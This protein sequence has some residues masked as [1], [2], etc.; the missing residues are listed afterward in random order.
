[1][2]NLLNDIKLE[3]EE[4]LQIFVAFLKVQDNSLILLVFFVKRII[5]NKEHSIFDKFFFCTTFVVSLFSITVYVL[6]LV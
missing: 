2:H 3:R 1:M 4:F 5:K 6:Q